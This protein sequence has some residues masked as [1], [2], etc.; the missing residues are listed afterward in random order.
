[1]MTDNSIMIVLDFSKKWKLIEYFAKIN[2]NSPITAILVDISHVLIGILKKSGETF[3]SGILHPFSKILQISIGLVGLGL[4]LEMNVIQYPYPVK[5]F[6]EKSRD[7]K[8]S[9]TS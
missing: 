2:E 1:M 7:M 8:I 6:L 4:R 5:I 3:V 9:H